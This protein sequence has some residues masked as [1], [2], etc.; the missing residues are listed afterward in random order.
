VWACYDNSCA[1]RQAVHVNNAPRP[2]NGMNEPWPALNNDTPRCN[3]DL[4]AADSTGTV[5]P[6]GEDEGFTIRWACYLI[7]AVEELHF[8]VANVSH[9]YNA[10]RLCAT[11]LGDGTCSVS[12]GVD[13]TRTFSTTVWGRT[14]VGNLVEVTGRT[15]VLG[16]AAR[17]NC[18]ATFGTTHT[19]PLLS[20]EVQ[21]KPCVEDPTLSFGSPD[22]FAAWS[23]IPGSDQNPPVVVGTVT[24]PA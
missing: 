15:N 10:V 24:V 2:A 18:D 21:T 23:Y 13:S 3:F 20:D 9:T 1:S 4:H 8:M 22:E 16:V 19:F 12:S 17:T 11:T 14:T 6:Y 7:P 5:I